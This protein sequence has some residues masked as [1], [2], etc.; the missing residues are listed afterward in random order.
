MDGLGIPDPAAVDAAWLGAALARAGVGVGAPGDLLAVEAAPIGTGQMGDSVR[1]RLRWRDGVEG[2]ATVVGKF[3]SSDARSRAAGQAGAYAKEIGFYRDLQP[4]VGV[5]TPVPHHLDLDEATGAFV[6]V[7]GD[8]RPAAQGDQ[9]RGCGLAEARLAVDAVVGLHAATWGRT[10]ELAF[11]WLPQPTAELLATRVAM[12]RQLFVGF[13]AMYGDAIGPDDVALG[14]WIGE[15]LAAVHTA[16]RLPRC[17]VHNDFRLDNLLFAT[18]EGP[19]PVTVVDWQTIGIGHGPVDL[20][21]FVG[22]GVW[23]PPEVDDERALVARYA[24]GLAARGV[25]ASADDLWDSYRLGAVS[26]YVMAVVASQ[27]VIRTERGDDM[28]VAMSTRH[29]HQMRRLGVAELV[30][31]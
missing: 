8:V 20:A 31:G 5:P 7:M 27:L 30:G 1:F 29:A 21:Y 22:A 26:G 9:L 25:S 17:V 12:Y 16:H 23:P 14:R 15:H 2:P 6:I 28:F 18:G 11:G 4:H 13:E 19:P 24:D 3:P 10:D